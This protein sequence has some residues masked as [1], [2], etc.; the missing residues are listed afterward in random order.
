MHCL[1]TQGFGLQEVQRLGEWLKLKSPCHQNIFRDQESK[2]NRDGW[3]QRHLTREA[4]GK[5]HES[6]WMDLLLQNALMCTVWYKEA[7]YVWFVFRSL[8]SKGG[9]HIFCFLGSRLSMSHFVFMISMTKKTLGRN[10]GNKI[11]Y[12]DAENHWICI[13]SPDM[14][15]SCR[16]I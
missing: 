10:V 12:L 7:Y 4:G 6:K 2:T 16:P 11:A 13:S 15:H 14:A 5:A 1:F 8:A 9:Q 3:H